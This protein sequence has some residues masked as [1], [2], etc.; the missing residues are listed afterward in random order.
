MN[1]KYKTIKR[2]ALQRWNDDVLGILEME[3]QILTATGSSN[4]DIYRYENSEPRYARRT[5]RQRYL[6]T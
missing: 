2:R 3:Y 1:A 4:P 6:P 5:K